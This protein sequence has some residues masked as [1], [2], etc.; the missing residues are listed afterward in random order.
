MAWLDL[1]LALLGVF[2]AAAFVVKRFMPKKPS[3]VADVE[4]KGALAEG[5]KRAQAKRHS[6]EES[7][8]LL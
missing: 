3:V 5:I 1:G 8:L 7:G 4:V 6:K 2:L